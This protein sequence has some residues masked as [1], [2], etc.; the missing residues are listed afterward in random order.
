LAPAK[1]IGV[2]KKFRLLDVVPSSHARATGATATHTPR[3]PAFDNLSD[4]S[5]PDVRKTPSD[6]DYA[7]CLDIEKSSPCYVFKLTSGAISWS[8]SK[9]SFIASSIMYAEFV[10][11]YEVTGQTLWVKKFMPSL[12]VIDNI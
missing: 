4:V 5:S 1:P 3:V 7:G 2:S 8:S 12:R 9:Q 10:A 11:C 6:S